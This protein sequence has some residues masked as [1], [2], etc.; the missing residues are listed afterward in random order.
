LQNYLKV[1]DQIFKKN[2][3][4]RPRNPYVQLGQ[5]YCWYN[6]KST[7]YFQSDSAE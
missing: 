6:Q 1:F 5:Y 4:S 2:I 7:Q 3:K